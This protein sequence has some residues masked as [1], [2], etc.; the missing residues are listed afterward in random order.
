M[1]KHEFVSKVSTEQMGGGTM[2]DFVTLNDGTVLGISDDCICLYAG[3]DEFE[4]SLEDCIE[5][6]TIE[7]PIA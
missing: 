3:M 7:R 5:V 4:A 6:P 2:M 1:D